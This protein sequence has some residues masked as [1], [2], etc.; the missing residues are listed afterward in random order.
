MRKNDV[1]A[2]LVADSA[3]RLYLT[4]KFSKKVINQESLMT[5]NQNTVSYF[6]NIRT[7]VGPVYAAMLLA[8]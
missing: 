4:V 8:G 7:Y 5:A 6:R 2:S 3:T 1:K